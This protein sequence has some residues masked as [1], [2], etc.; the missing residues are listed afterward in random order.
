VY[1]KGLT[2]AVSFPPT[3]TVTRCHALSARLEE[4]YDES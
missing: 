3:E 4:S 1:A 2:G